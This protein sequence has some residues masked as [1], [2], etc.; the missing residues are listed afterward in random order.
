MVFLV[1]QKKEAMHFETYRTTK[2]ARG[3]G[4]EL[5]ATRNLAKSR[6][7]RSKSRGEKEQPNW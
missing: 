5:E 7:D 3:G 6:L 1:K 2:K 4:V